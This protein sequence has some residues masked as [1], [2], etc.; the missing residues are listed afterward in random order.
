MIFG[1]WHKICFFFNKKVNTTLISNIQAHIIQRPKGCYL[2]AFIGINQKEIKKII[3]FETKSNDMIN[4]KKISNGWLQTKLNKE[5]MDQQD[6]K[7]HFQLAI[8]N[9]EQNLIEERIPELQKSA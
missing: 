9:L 7:K 1:N 6:Y 4:F 2:F 3:F 5:E 8:I